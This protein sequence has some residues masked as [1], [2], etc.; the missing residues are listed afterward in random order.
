MAG[1]GDGDDPMEG[2][3]AGDRSGLRLG[4]AV[5]VATTRTWSFWPAWQWPGKPQ[6]K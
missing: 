6:R 3:G 4:L 5:E 2:E 1:E